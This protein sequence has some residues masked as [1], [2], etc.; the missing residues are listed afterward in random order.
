MFRR[1]GKEIIAGLIYHPWTFQVHTWRSTFNKI[2][3]IIA[4]SRC[5]KCVDN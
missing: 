2:I 1:I 3:S 4:S 5:E